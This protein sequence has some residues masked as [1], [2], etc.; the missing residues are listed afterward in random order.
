M[1]KQ[2]CFAFVGEESQLDHIPLAEVD[3][4][5]E[6]KDSTDDD[7]ASKD[8]KLRHK[9][10]I[11][12]LPSGY[13]S[14]RTYYISTPSKDQMI[15]LMTKM[16]SNAKTE[17]KRAEASSLFRKWQLKF[18]RRYESNLIKGTMALMIAAVSMI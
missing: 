1:H 11:A 4:V 9:I 3:F 2:I 7:D 13:N 10:Q 14:G 18:R 5:L 16:R 6:M 8:D 15:N 12:T 17:R